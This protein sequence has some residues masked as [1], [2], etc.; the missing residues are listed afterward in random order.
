MQ[1]TAS[2]TLDTLD[3]LCILCMLCVACMLAIRGKRL[4]M[5]GFGIVAPHQSRA[6]CCLPAVRKG[7][8]NLFWVL[9]LSVFPRNCPSMLERKKQD[10]RRGKTGD[11]CKG[12]KVRLACVAFGTRIPLLT[13]GRLSHSLLERCQSRT[14]SRLAR[15][16]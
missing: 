15:P 7:L 10:E 9:F 16:S 12:L 11:S 14:F 6:L 2:R 13:V 5:R 3:T 1:Q 4:G 8:E